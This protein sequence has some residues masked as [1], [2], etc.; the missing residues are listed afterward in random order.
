MQRFTD[1]RQQPANRN[2]SWQVTDPSRTWEAPDS[3]LA[4]IE[5]DAP[6]PLKDRKRYLRDCRACGV[7]PQCRRTQV[8]FDEHIAEAAAAIQA[9]EKLSVITERMGVNYGTMYRR[10]VKL[11]LPTTPPP[12]HTQEQQT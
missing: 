12:N 11:G 1:P 3:L 10:L 8:V 9:G 2:T 6:P 4:E 5:R 7:E